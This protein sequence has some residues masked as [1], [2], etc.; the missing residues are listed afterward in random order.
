MGDSR[1]WHAAERPQ[2][3]RPRTAFGSHPHPHPHPYPPQSHPHPLPPPL[4]S[5]LRPSRSAAQLRR[6]RNPHDAPPP[7]PGSAP[8]PDTHLV[9]PP[10][11]PPSRLKGLKA[12]LEE[13]QFVAGGLVGRP[14]ESTTC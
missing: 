2:T 7:P 5:P 4:P 11:P 6:H 1:Q 12:A 3:S 14:A 8:P 9:D 10:P 13:A